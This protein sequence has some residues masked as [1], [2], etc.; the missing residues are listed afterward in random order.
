MV[1]VVD[2]LCRSREVFI[3]KPDG[4]AGDEVVVTDCDL[5]RTNEGLAPHDLSVT[6]RLADRLNAR[7]AA[8]R[9]PRLFD[10]TFDNKFS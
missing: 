4:L 1:P 6:Y 10:A 9:P 5:K 3:L 2:D 8:T 7:V